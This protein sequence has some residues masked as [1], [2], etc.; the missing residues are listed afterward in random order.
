MLRRRKAKQSVGPFPS[1]ETKPHEPCSAR[2][3]EGSEGTFWKKSYYFLINKIGARQSKIR[4]KNEQMIMLSRLAGWPP[5]T[6][7]TT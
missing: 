2:K 5:Q 7:T 3:D 4:L 6:S 1:P